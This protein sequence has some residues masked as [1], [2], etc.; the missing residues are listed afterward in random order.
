M[1]IQRIHAIFLAAGFKPTSVPGVWQRRLE[2]INLDLEGAEPE[3]LRMMLVHFAAVYDL[4][5]SD[6][7]DDG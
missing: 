5:V 2:F 7:V 4:D 3:D 1:N 6:I